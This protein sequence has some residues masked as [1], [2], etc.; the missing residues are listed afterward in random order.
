VTTPLSVLAFARRVGVDESAV[1]KGIK[2]GRLERSLGHD[3]RGRSV[4]ADVALAEQEWRLNRN[5][6]KVRGTD[7]DSGANGARGTIADE[8]RLLTREQRRREELKNAILS[9]QY[10]PVIEYRRREIARTVRAKNALLGLP[11]KAKQR[12]PSLTVAEVGILDA[13]VR[14]CLEAL[15]DDELTTEATT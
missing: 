13:L 1:R 15:A 9:G 2:N 10:A 3:A 11:S 14:E 8:R 12:I 7:G 6:A 5:E 4:I